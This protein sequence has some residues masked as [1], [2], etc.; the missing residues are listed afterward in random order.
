MLTRVSP[1]PSLGGHIKGAAVSLSFVSNT[2]PFLP[3]RTVHLHIHIIMSAAYAPILPNAFVTKQQYQA[4]VKGLADVKARID[5]T[6][7][8]GQ[9]AS[10]E[11][12]NTETLV[13]GL[14]N[15]FPD[16]GEDMTWLDKSKMDRVFAIMAHHEKSEEW[17]RGFGATYR[18]QAGTVIEKFSGRD[19]WG[20]S[21]VHQQDATVFTAIVD[22]T[23]QMLAYQQE[24]E[25]S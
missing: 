20:N 13:Q 3:L 17:D 1:F 22:Q 11:D 7:K 19:T 23:I 10:R 15:V 9:A 12:Y 4:L 2:H 24:G 14:L 8:T 21:S 25:L 6:L 18:E 16:T 5:R